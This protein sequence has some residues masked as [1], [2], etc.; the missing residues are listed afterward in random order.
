MISFLEKLVDELLAKHGD[1]LSHLCLVFPTRRA[2]LY[3]KKRYSAKLSS[4]AWSPA[5][6]S[7]EDFVQSMSAL[8]S[9][10]DLDLVFE[11]FKVYKKYFPDE[12]FERFYPWGVMLLKD[13]NEVDSS[14]ADGKKLFASITDLK[15]MEEQFGLADE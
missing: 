1:D 2:G 11:L 15:S 9:G 8:Q 7:I 10:D 12:T 14:L 3:F 13:F 4:P 5:V 6:F